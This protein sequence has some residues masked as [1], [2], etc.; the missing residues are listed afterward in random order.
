MMRFGPGFVRPQLPSA[1]TG[2][3]ISGSMPRF[4]TNMPMPNFP[5]PRA[6]APMNGPPAVM[7]GGPVTPGGFGS[8]GAITGRTGGVY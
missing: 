6:V 2:G 5:I 7:S 4:S 8:L 3:G 1:P